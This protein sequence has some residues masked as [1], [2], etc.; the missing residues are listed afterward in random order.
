MITPERAPESREGIQH[1]ERE[2]REPEEQRR[3]PATRRKVRR[4]EVGL[5]TRKIVNGW[6]AYYKKFPPG[7]ESETPGPA[8]GI[9]RHQRLSAGPAEGGGGKANSELSV[10]PQSGKSRTGGDGGPVGETSL[11]TGA[12]ASSTTETSDEDDG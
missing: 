6:L 1:D 7:S 11:E 2:R 9:A 5:F 12:F 10:S 3:R 4:W 8:G